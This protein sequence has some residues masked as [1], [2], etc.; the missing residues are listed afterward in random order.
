MSLF[1]VSG[2]E[3][4]LGNEKRGVV[5]MAFSSTITEGRRPLVYE[6]VNSH[7]KPDLRHRVQG[8]LPVHRVF[9]LCVRLSHASYKELSFSDAADSLFATITRSTN[10]CPLSVFPP[11]LRRPLLPGNRIW[12]RGDLRLRA[13]D[14]RRAVVSH[15]WSVAVGLHGLFLL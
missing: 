14:V 1:D 12:W 8:H 4:W 2:V 3:I 7:G 10:P 9:F 6:A 11:P 5:D 15:S 13:C